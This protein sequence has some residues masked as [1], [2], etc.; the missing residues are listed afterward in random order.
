MKKFSLFSLFGL[1]AFFAMPIYAE[2]VYFDENY[3]IVPED[4]AVEAVENVAEEAAVVADEITEDMEAI[5]EEIEDVVLAA[6]E[7]PIIERNTDSD[8]MP[9]YDVSD[10]DGITSVGLKS[11]NNANRLL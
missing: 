8:F 9:A 5:A 7:E 4:T 2:D 6:E 10:F 1:L 11:S 3:I